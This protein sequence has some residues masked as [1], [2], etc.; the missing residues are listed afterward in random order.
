MFIED[1]FITNFWVPGI[2]LEAAGVDLKI[3]PAPHF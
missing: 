1:A 3:A 2:G